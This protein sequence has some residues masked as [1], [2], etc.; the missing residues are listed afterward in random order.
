MQ[1]LEAAAISEKP[2]C[3]AQIAKSIDIGLRCQDFHYL[4]LKIL[5]FRK[6]P[7]R[8][9]ECIASSK[10]LLSLLLHLSPESDEP[11]HPFLW[12][13]LYSP[14]TAF[15]LLFR[16]ILLNPGRESRD[17]Q[18]ALDA[19]ENLPK[20]LEKIAPQ[21]PLATRLR[22]V[23]R[24][25]I[26]HAQS[27]LTQSEQPRAGSDGPVTE[28]T[29]TSNETANSFDMDLLG[30]QSADM[31]RNPFSDLMTDDIFE[32]LTQDFEGNGLFDWMTWLGEM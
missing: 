29:F 2:F 5:L 16:E 32:S 3:D 11:Y 24:V 27:V 8:R 13:F 23:S 14:F 15:L 19:M 20:F 7:P 12:Q 28:S 1:T 18:E 10:E 4:Y 31:A 9:F 26:S 30:N 17:N 6:S 25:L 22:E 21:N